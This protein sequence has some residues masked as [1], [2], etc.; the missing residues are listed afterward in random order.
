M[1]KYFI[2]LVL[3]SSL[4]PKLTKTELCLVST[5]SIKAQSSET[6]V[7]LGDAYCD[8]VAPQAPDWSDDYF[9]GLGPGSPEGPDGGQ[10]G[11]GGSPTPDPNPNPNPNPCAIAISPDISA[12]FRDQSLSQP[13]IDLKDYMKNNTNEK[14]FT[15]SDG[16]GGYKIDWSC[17]A[18]SNTSSLTYSLDTE[19][20]VHTHPNNGTFS[21][22]DL[23]VLIST[24][25]W[26]DHMDDSYILCADGNVYNLHIDDY[27]AA[28]N[29]FQNFP[30]T[31]SDGSFSTSTAFGQ[32]FTDIQ[33]DIG[34]N[35]GYD[36]YGTNRNIDGG[37][38]WA[39][40]LDKYNVGVSISK[41]ESDGSFK[42][43]IT[44]KQTDN[45]KDKYVASK[46]E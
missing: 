27:Q 33:T 45:G 31:N 6:D 13:I 30:S 29:F 21:P 4:V 17:T 8:G 28:Y 39:Y 7:Q 42:K 46:C 24:N 35:Q 34:Y 9:S 32:D 1:K 20:S 41:Q 23:F 40:V 26:N 15:I 43:L 12:L 5:S 36:P 3:L 2:I 10:S 18:T 25:I 14:G 38:A 44:E 37:F 22:Q 11:G 19:A 16:N